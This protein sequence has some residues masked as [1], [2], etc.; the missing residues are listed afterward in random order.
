MIKRLK[1]QL[2]KSPYIFVLLLVFPLA[3][4]FLYARYSASQFFVFLAGSL[5]VIIAYL[6]YEYVSLGQRQAV[7]SLERGECEERFNL[8]QAEITRDRQANDS[9]QVKITNYSLLKDLTE[10]LCASFSLAD[11]SHIIAADVNAVYQHEDMTVIVYF[12]KGT[13]GEVSL[14]ASLRGQNPLNLKAKRGDLYDQWVSKN[15]K[16]LLIEDTKND[17]RFDPEQI[18]NEDERTVRSLMSVPLS[19]GEKTIGVLRVDSS[20][21]HQFSTEDLRFLNTVG[22]IG[23]VALENAQ[24]YERVEDL[25][26]RDSLTGLFL[27]RHLMERLTAEISRHLRSD[28][29]LSFLMIDLDHFK[30][31]NDKFGHTAGD[32][33]L[34]T[35]A[36]ILTDMFTEPGQIVCRYG[37]EEFCVL[38]PDCS[39]RKAGQLAEDVRKRIEA[40]TIILR[41][42]KTHITVSIGVAAFPRDS[43]TKEDL[44]QKA[45][46]ALYE[47]KASGRNQVV[48]SSPVSKEDK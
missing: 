18:R 47:A 35:I 44:V 6:I 11:T 42:E 38:L 23:A 43:H 48:I 46:A 9:L 21:E 30:K 5:A 16:P 34:K 12:L 37:G 40:Q 17:F 1:A 29:E 41:R 32:I 15:L 19:V 22:S 14:I 27:R 7:I 3:G 26:I 10:K 28:E 24:L 33:V 25:A 36:M 45:D 20:M 2:F 8:L 31:Y 4:F 13:V 39:K